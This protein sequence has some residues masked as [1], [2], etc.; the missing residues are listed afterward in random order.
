MDDGSA[1]ARFDSGDIVGACGA[2]WKFD[3]KNLRIG[4]LDSFG[5]FEG[6]FACFFSV[7]FLDFSGKA[8]ASFEFEVSEIESFSIY[9]V[10][11]DNAVVSIEADDREG[12]IGCEIA[13]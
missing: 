3:D 11:G 2:V 8:A 7:H 12:G 10:C 9:E 13:F 1:R 6:G 5:N 4:R